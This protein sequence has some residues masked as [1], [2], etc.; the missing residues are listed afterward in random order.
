VV[1]TYNATSQLTVIA[2]VDYDKQDFRDGGSATWYG[3]AL[4]AN[5]ALNDAWRVSVRGEYLDDK[6]GFNFGAP[7][8]LWEGTVTVGFAPTKSFELRLEGR[9]DTSQTNV[10]SKAAANAFDSDSLSEFAIQG[11]Y[12]F[13]AP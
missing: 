1:A 7:Q 12:K 2:N 6:D 4:Y 8:H 10:F 11:V 5:Y 9:Y 13:S 3:A